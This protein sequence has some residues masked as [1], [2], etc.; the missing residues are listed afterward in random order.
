MPS[1]NYGNGVQHQRLPPY[2]KPK[3]SSGNAC[4]KC[5]CCCYGFLILMLII[6]AGLT[7]YLYLEYKPEIP[8]Y[9]YGDNSDVEAYFKT[10]FL[11]SGKLPSFKQGHKNIT[12]MNIEM[13]GE[14]GFGTA[15]QDALEE[16]QKNGQVPLLVTVKA[17]VNIILGSLQLR[18]FTVHVKC[19]L[20]LDSLL[21]G[22]K[23]KIVS[24]RYD[25]DASF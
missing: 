5:I 11:C 4:L 22:N 2:G 18:E 17:P 13:K 9:R 20:V 23:P 25:I 6:I 3:K 1:P 14:N 15:L 10:T 19:Y 7:F 21:S 8:S 24:S 16:S 12:I